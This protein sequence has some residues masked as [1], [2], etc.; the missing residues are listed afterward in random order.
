MWYTTALGFACIISLS[1]CA[2]VGRGEVPKRV[3][4]FDQVPLSS[5]PSTCRRGSAEVCDRDLLGHRASAT[6]VPPVLRTLGFSTGRQE[7]QSEN[8]SP[9]SGPADHAPTGNAAAIK[10]VSDDGGLPAV[11]PIVGPPGMTSSRRTVRSAP[12]ASVAGLM[13]DPAVSSPVNAPSNLTAGRKRDSLPPLPPLRSQASSAPQALEDST[14]ASPATEPGSLLASPGRPARRIETDCSAEMERTINAKTLEIIHAGLEEAPEAKQSRHELGSAEL[15]ETPRPAKT[16]QLAET[17]EL[18]AT[19]PL[20]EIPELLVETPELVETPLLAQVPLAETPPGMETPEA[21]ETSKAESFFAETQQ[22]METPSMVEAPELPTAQEDR[23]QYALGPQA[24]QLLSGDEPAS[25]ILPAFIM[26]DF[27]AARS[28]PSPSRS[29]GEQTILAGQSPRFH[30]HVQEARLLRASENI[31][32]VV[33]ENGHVCDVL[34]FNAREVA[35]IGRTQG[36]MQL[37]FWYDGQGSRRASYLVTV[38]EPPAP[39][40]RVQGEAQKLETLLGHLF[41]GSRIECHREPDRLIV[42]GYAVSQRQA[43]DILSLVRRSQLIPVVD[44]IEIRAQGQ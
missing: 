22:A 9:S 11:K 18:A 1:A 29:T 35:L 38:Q 14:I 24:P 30:L 8:K 20:V 43:V 5:A 27:P 41:P 3:E 34:V 37:D 10:L 13:V 28:D 33:S 21:S 36:T 12:E 19:P 7:P 39:T 42:R 44:L 2:E 15:V 16:P 26:S 32:R 17:T 23:E 6:R 31:Y 25:A 40:D 4:V